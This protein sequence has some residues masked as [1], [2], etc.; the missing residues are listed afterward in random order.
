MFNFFRMFRRK[1]K[2]PKSPYRK[3]SK[4]L[5]VAK[6]EGYNPYDTLP[7]VPRERFGMYRHDG[8]DK[9]RF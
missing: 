5:N 1:E 3:S 2:M 8:D 6:E 7:G 4:K 9:W